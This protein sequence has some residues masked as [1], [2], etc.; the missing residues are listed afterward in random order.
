MK[1]VNVVSM[2]LIL[3]L[4]G[5]GP[6]AINV[7]TSFEQA[8][9]AY[10]R[11]LTTHPDPIDTQ[12]YRVYMAKAKT[13]YDK[14]DYDDAEK[15]A[16]QALEQANNAYNT[17]QQLQKDAKNNIEQIRAK[18]GNLLVPSH[19][20]IHGFFEAINSYNA[21]HYR[22]CISTLSDV[23]K[24]LDIDAQT[25]FLHKV[26]LYVPENLKNKFGSNIPVF[27]FLGNDMKLHNQITSIK[28]PVEVD[29]VNQFFVNE[30]FSYFHIKDSKLHIDGWVYPQFVI[31]GKVKE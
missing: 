11:L 26:T 30:N 20:A 22:Q 25:A 24:R 3:L 31:I 18:M 14:G 6:S 29:F 15:Y 27:A 2:L 17:R 12:G 4:M 23:S 16:Q 28:G 7:K 1:R 19:E 21:G 13:A 8:E 10:N 5:C 9:S